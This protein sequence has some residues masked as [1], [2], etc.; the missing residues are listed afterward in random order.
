MNWISGIQ[1][2]IDYIEEHLTESIRYDEIAKQSYSS[3]FHLQRVF[4]ILCGYTLGEYI[5]NR[6]LA[7]A[8][9]E[10]ALGKTKIIDIALKYG[11]ENP[12][13]FSRAFVKFHGINPSEAS[14][15]GVRLQS[16]SPLKVKVFLEGG[17]TMNY[18]IEEK[19]ETVL[20]GFKQHFYGIPF[21]EQRAKQEEKMFVSSRAK[22]WLLRGASC[23]YY[24]D[25]CIVKNIDDTGYDFYIAN[26][27]D[28]W[29][30]ANLYNQ[31]ITG[32]DFIESMEFEEIIIPKQKYVI[33][34]TQ[35]SAHPIEEYVDIRQKLVAEWLPLSGYQF[36]DASE[37][38]LLHWRPKSSK[39]NRFIEIW[40][41]IEKI[42]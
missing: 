9:K 25:Y 17:M 33:F 8:G 38:A 12:E 3:S 41:P 42:T 29:T 13:S 2:V 23:D 20:V 24:T 31:E 34:E 14:K 1:S 26:E 10:L 7:L 16:F 21:G 11:Y 27:L 30:R 4:S 40:I 36:A 39:E 28:D 35:Q 19:P 15:P 37:L 32:V 18:R 5:R 22:Q 6:R